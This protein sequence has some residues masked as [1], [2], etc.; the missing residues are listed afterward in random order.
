MFDVMFGSKPASKFRDGLH[1]CFMLP[2][3]L[4]SGP[5]HFAVGIANE[6]FLLRLMVA[7]HGAILVAF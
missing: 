7:S 5:G 3:V 4:S 2:W 1:K 6:S